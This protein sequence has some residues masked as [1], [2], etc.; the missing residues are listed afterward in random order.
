MCVLEDDQTYPWQE[1]TV[2]TRNFKTRGLPDVKFP[3]ATI[4]A[5]VNEFLNSTWMPEEISISVTVKPRGWAARKAARAERRRAAKR[6]EI[7]RRAQMRFRSIA[8]NLNLPDAIV[9]ASEQGELPAAQF[10]VGAI[11]H[12]GE[13]APE[14]VSIG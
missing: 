9:A 11:N 10:R 2:R 12:M 13:H 8:S 7:L 14:A 5:Q 4:M 3:R 1:T 6:A